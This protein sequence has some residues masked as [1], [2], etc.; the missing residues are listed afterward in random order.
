[1]MMGK[2]LAGSLLVGA[3]AE[4]I[5]FPERKKVKITYVSG[6]SP[7]YDKRRRVMIII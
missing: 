2:G 3:V 1:M 6:S 4:H 5:N 7:H